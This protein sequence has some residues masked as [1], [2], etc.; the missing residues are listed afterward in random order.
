MAITRLEITQLRNV[1]RAEIGLGPGLN[2]FYGENGAGKTAILEAVHLL[3][4]GQSF[5]GRDKNNL[6]REGGERMVVRAL[7]EDEAR[8]ACSVGVQ[9]K[10]N[11]DGRLLI[12]GRDG[13][14]QSEIA[15]LVPVQAMLPTVGDLVFGNPSV[16]RRF[17]DWGVF[18][19]KP[20]YIEGLRTYLRLLR[21]R[22]ALLKSVATG[23]A[24]LA[25]LGVWDVRLGEA[26]ER[27][28]EDRSRY[29]L[30]LEQAFQNILQ[31]LEPDL[32][33]ACIYRRGWSDLPLVKVL[34]EMAAKEVKWGSTRVGPQRADLTLTCQGGKASAILSRG[35]GKLVAT[36]MVL[37]QVQLLVSSQGRRTVLLI[38]DLGAEI[39]QPRVRRM[40]KV[41]ADTGAQVLATS[42]MTP[43]TVSAFWHDTPPKMFHVKQGEVFPEP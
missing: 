17:L 6:I 34:G 35:Q 20:S 31:I 18:H 41:I 24:T 5:R 15:V 22:N 16:R 36:A 39:D 37:A 25:E 23:R 29:M 1:K 12:D 40:L 8:G 7:I 4:R 21:Q 38:D 2:Y 11:G 33:I 26:G 43:D 9:R 13:G 10:R 28:S 19:V 32:D 14:K 27:V 42:T 3:A 30:D